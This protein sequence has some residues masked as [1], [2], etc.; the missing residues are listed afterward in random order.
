MGKRAAMAGEDCPEWMRLLG[1]GDDEET[2]ADAEEGV[3]EIGCAGDEE[4]EAEAEEYLFEEVAAEAAVAADAAEAGVAAASDVAEMAEDEEP[5][6]E[7]G[8]EFRAAFE[9]LDDAPA[10]PPAAAPPK[11]QK[12][13]KCASPA[14]ATVAPAKAP[15]KTLP[16][17]VGAAKAPPARRPSN[18]ALQAA[19]AAATAPKAPHA[20]RPVGPRATNAQRPAV[21]KLANGV[22]SAPTS[23]ASSG[24]PRAAGAYTG[25]PAAKVAVAESDDAAPAADEVAAKKA[26]IAAVLA[27]KRA[28]AKAAPATTT[29]S[30]SGDLASGHAAA[31][32]T[33]P[34]RAGAAAAGGNSGGKS[35]SKGKPGVQLL[36]RGKN[37]GVAK[38][39][40]KGSKTSGGIETSAKGAKKGFKKGAAEAR[41][42]A[43]GDQRAGVAPAQAEAFGHK[44]AGAP[45]AGAPQKKGQLGEVEKRV[46]REGR[47]YD[48]AKVI[49]NFANVGSTYGKKLLKREA[50]GP[51]GLMDWEGVR[52]CCRYMKNEMKLQVVGV[53]NENY[54]ATDNNSAQKRPMPE[55]IRKMCESIEETPRLPGQQHCSADDEMTIKCAYRRNCYF[56]DN[57]HYRDWKQQ[58]ANDKIRMWLETHAD[59]LQMRYYFDSGLGTFDLLEG[60]VSKALL[61]PDK[62]VAPKK[63]SKEELWTAPRK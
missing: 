6:N 55:D 12:V 14:A 45:L 59:F 38:G 9:E 50:Q 2:G 51:R 29:E 57:D 63:L 20:H 54:T 41:A 25:R 56:L 26:R 61:A 32:A 15:A 44:R 21:P 11:I 4:A 13:S 42:D 49:V 53:I 3:V 40:M 27:A 47:Q 36:N 33:P 18:P 39:T 43:L 62:G 5:P 30:R 8:A 35:D 17:Q 48:L 16:A 60:N 31:A 28:K 1:G 24:G 23:S 10:A 7:A 19:I 46:D 37:G 58:L 52:R 34:W 22:A